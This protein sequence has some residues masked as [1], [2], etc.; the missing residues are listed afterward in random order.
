MYMAH[1]FQHIQHMKYLTVIHVYIIKYWTNTRLD[2]LGDVLSCPWRLH[3]QFKWRCYQARPWEATHMYDNNV[4]VYIYMYIL[5]YI[6]MYILVYIYMYI[7]VYIYMYILVYIYM[8]ILVYIYMYILV[9][10]Y[11]YILVYIYRTIDPYLCYMYIV[12][13]CIYGGDNDGDFSSH[14]L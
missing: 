12:S 10:I 4:H 7:L 9:Y 6:Y 8:Y 3:W 13:L 14:K 2:E 5:V 11:M 1:G